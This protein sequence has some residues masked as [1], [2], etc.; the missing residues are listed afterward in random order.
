LITVVVNETPLIPT[1]VTPINY[2]QNL[3]SVPLTASVNIGT[4]QWYTVPTGGIGSTTAPIPSTATAGNVTYYVS[5]K[6]GNCEGPRTPIV[7]NVTATP[8]LPSVTTPV[9]YCT[10]VTAVPLTATGSSLLWYTTPTG[11]TGSTI[12]PTP[13]TTT[14]GTTPYYVTQS[15]SGVVCEGPRALINVVI[16][17]RPIAPTVVSPVPYCQNVNVVALTATG[18]AGNTF[19]WYTTSIGGTGVSNAPIPSTSVVGSTTYY[20]S[21]TTTA[22]TCEGARTPI[23][24]NVTPE[25]TVNAGNDTIMARGNTIQLNGSSTGVANAT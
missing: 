13:S 16:N 2:C 18:T 24:V 23:T 3:P 14:A 20:V 17:P 5:G 25:L 7:V 10:N 1:V 6:L 19:L 15:T 8:A 11:G 21:Q 9:T 4:L 22:T 12:A